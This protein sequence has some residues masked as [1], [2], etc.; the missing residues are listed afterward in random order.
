[1]CG[2]KERDAIYLIAER[3]EPTVVEL[4]VA[5]Q[6][7]S[8]LQFNSKG[9]LFSWCWLW[10]VQS[11][12]VQTSLW[13]SYLLISYANA[14]LVGLDLMNNQMY[15]Y[16]PLLVLRIVTRVSFCKHV[17]AP[18]C[19]SLL[20]TGRYSDSSRSWQWWRL[21]RYYLFKLTHIFQF[22]FSFSG[23]DNW[24]NVKTDV[25]T[26]KAATTTDFETWKRSIRLQTV[27]RLKGTLAFVSALRYAPSTEPLSRSDE[28]V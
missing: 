3:C 6:P 22:Q 23:N 20:H 7:R 4:N 14:E 28:W 11:Y 15:L 2:L 16:C 9:F 18:L 21:T 24:L 19:H 13:S 1:M 25:F 10:V 17:V 26:H 8:A 27:Y 12:G 5:I